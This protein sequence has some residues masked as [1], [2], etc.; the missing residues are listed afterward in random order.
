MIRKSSIIVITA[1]L[2]LIAADIFLAAGK[3]Q[4][5]HPFVSDGSFC[6]KC[7]EKE[8]FEHPDKSCTPYCLTCHSTI[9]SKHHPVD[10]RLKKVIDIELT[11]NQRIACRTCHNLKQKRYDATSWRA[12]SL[13]EKV[14]RKETTYKTFF[15]QTRNTNG[16]LCKKCH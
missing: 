10:V 4:D 1:S 15:L 2:L 6:K 13:Y 11:D 8:T 12:E 14:F 5:I 3:E 16:E 7:H 9:G